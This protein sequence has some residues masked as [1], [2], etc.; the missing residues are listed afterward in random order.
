[1][2]EDQRTRCVGAIV[3]PQV[4]EGVALDGA[5][6][7]GETERAA[8]HRLVGPAAEIVGHVA[9]RLLQGLGAAYDEVGAVA[10]IG[11]RAQ[12]DIAG[13]VGFVLDED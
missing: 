5:A 7:E 3:D 12:F 2:L 10:A 9:I 13:G 4:I 8:A 6:V 11:H 1:M